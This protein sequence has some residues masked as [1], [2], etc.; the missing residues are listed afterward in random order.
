MASRG[1]QPLARPV[2]L[3]S[4]HFD[5]SLHM[6]LAKLALATAFAFAGSAFAADRTAD[7]P[8]DGKNADGKI[9]KSEA[10]NASR[11]DDSGFAKLDKNKDGYISKAEA[12]G[13]KT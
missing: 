10:A 3:S 9:S 4:I 2:R 8:F 13:N 5:R 11:S 12:A 6:K 7:K 1:S